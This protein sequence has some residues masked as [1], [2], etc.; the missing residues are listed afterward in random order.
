M[1][2]LH[3]LFVRLVGGAVRPILCCG[4]LAAG[5]LVADGVYT[6]EQADRGRVLYE[7]ACA[8][9]HGAALEGETSG[10]LVGPEFIASWARPELTLDDFYYIVR[11]TMPKETPGSLTREAYTDIVAYILQRNGF[12][13]GEKELSPDPALM[14]TVRFGASA[15]AEHGHSALRSR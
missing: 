12:P 4:L 10:P 5:S 3:P 13:E 2:M 1:A 6:K 11:K 9:C 14:K 15:P 8:E 7:G